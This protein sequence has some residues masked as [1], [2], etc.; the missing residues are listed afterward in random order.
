MS[1]GCHVHQPYPPHLSF[2]PPSLHSNSNRHTSPS[3]LARHHKSRLLPPSCSFGQPPAATSLLPVPPAP[4]L[5]KPTVGMEKSGS[6]PLLFLL[7][8][9]VP[10]NQR[11]ITTRSAPPSLRATKGSSEHR[12]HPQGIFFC[13][14]SSSNPAAWPQK[15]IGLLPM[16][17][18]VI[19]A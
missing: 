5:K 10:E 18:N 3:S 2:L 4:Q 11:R 14:R 17:L 13:F 12:P 19:V 8:C 1:R 6:L 9:S 16:P 15:I 7:S